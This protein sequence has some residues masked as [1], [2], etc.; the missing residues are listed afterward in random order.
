MVYNDDDGITM[1]DVKG[2]NS[3]RSM[4]DDPSKA[5]ATA[6]DINHP[7]YRCQA[8]TEVADMLA[9][10]ARLSLLEEALAAAYEQ[11]QPN[12]IANVACWPLHSL[13][14]FNPTLSQQWLTRLLN[15]IALEP[16]GLRRLHGLAHIL[17]SVMPHETL[18]EQALKDF[19]ATAEVSFGD[20]IERLVAAVAVALAK[21]EYERA[22]ALL[23]SRKP[24]RRIRQAMRQLGIAQ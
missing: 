14:G 23:R 2:R 7:W 22:C 21:Y 18:R 8:L 17:F 13:L 4:A 1:A 5:L 9:A 20:R 12:Q 10:S 16:H 3:I 11:S 6:R 15:T 19:L 24:D